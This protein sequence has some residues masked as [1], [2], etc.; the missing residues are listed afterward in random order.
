MLHADPPNLE[1][2]RETARRTI[3]DGNRAS[4]VVTRLRA[5]FSQKS[6]ALES[7]DLNDVAREVIALSVSQLQRNG[8]IVQTDLAE[9]LLSV[10]GDRIQIQQVIVNLIRNAS[11]AMSTVEDRPRELLI[12]TES[13]QGGGVRLSVR[14]T[15]VGLEGS[16]QSSSRPSIRQRATA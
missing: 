7:V 4:E 8:V 9:E 6:T 2:A 13:D 15:G 1:G 14:D 12:K 16:R 10:R 5:L 3:R 11:D